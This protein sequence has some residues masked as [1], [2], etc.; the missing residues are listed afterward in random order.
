MGSNP[1]PSIPFQCFGRTT[2]EEPLETHPF[3]SEGWAFL[4]AP[5]PQPAATLGAI[6]AEST[7][8]II[9]GKD[10]IISFGFPKEAPRRAGL[11]ISCPA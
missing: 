4:F 2:D 11:A 1:T 3:A 10:G 8:W 6:S 9:A 7:L 5:W